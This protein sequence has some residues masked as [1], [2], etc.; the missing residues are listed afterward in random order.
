MDK[1]AASARDAIADIPDGATVM[2]GGFASAG[3][4]TNLILALYDQ[5]TTGIT[6]IA[7]NIG[8]GDKLDLL[9]EKK[10]IR[11]LIASFAIR[12]SARQQS[13]FEALYE[14]GEV[15]ME[16]VPQGTLAE[17]IRAGGAGIPAFYTA[18]GA[19]TVVAQGKETRQFNGREYVLEQALT[20][21]FAFVKADRADRLGN[22]VYRKAGRNFNTVMAMAAR[23]TIAEA[24]EVVEPG[25]LDPE[26]IGT[27]G[28]FVQRVVQ[29]PRHDVRWL[30]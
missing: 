27:P 23:V 20:A 7:N 26:A 19:G 8:L 16:V 18:T 6:A 15:E 17:R 21:D 5:G 4:P 2:F 29:G 14:A 28:I 22:L 11:K 3:T 10:Q 25:Q 9:C 30:N 13:R 1:V 24:E 12:A